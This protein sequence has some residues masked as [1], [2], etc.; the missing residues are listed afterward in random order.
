[1]DIDDPVGHADHEDWWRSSDSKQEHGGGGWVGLGSALDH[2]WMP[3]AGD[4]HNDGGS[5]VD[6][7]GDLSA[8]ASGGLSV[9]ASVG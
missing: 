7:S 1:M 4:S 9:G 2:G 5:S 6:A 8:G 3:D